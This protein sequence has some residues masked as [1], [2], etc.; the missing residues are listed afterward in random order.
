MALEPGLLAAANRGILYVDEINLLDDHLADVLLDA[1]AMGVNTVEREGV[2]IAHPARFMLVGTMNPEEGDLRPQ[3]ADRIGLHVE[4]DGI[5]DSSVRAE[6]L[7]RREAWNADPE[8]FAATWDEQQ[9]ALR[10]RLARAVE[11]L[12]GVVV[13]REL[14]GA[15]ARLVVRM[16]VSSHRADITILEC[17]KA[18]AA[19]GGRGEVEEGDVFEAAALALGHRI[20]F[21]PFEPSEGLDERQLRRVL[22]DVLDAEKKAPPTTAAAAS[23]PTSPSWK[24]PPTST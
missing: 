23:T 11:L 6:V 24:E 2:S 1:A 8:A 14:Y 9:Q 4:V 16:G 15:I 21:D 12:P 7:R 5:E 10:A 22:E 17:A 20:A 13:R 18:T 3:L 19:L